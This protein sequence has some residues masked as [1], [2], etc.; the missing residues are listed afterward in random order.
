MHCSGCGKNLPFAGQVCP[1]CQRDKSADQSST[2]IAGVALL[3]G[4]F[5]G[6]L[7]GGFGGMIIGGLAL[8]L[9]A[10]VATMGSTTKAAKKPPRVRVEPAPTLPPTST[11]KPSDAAT[12]RL[13]RLDRLRDTGAITD[14]EYSQQRKAVIASL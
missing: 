14:E 11:V 1:H 4:G 12:E 10:V 5:I 3:F 7:I 13:A 9:I 6:N 2:V 8:A